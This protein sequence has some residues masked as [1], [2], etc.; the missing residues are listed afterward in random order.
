MLASLSVRTDGNDEVVYHQE[1]D[2]DEGDDDEDRVD[3]GRVLLV[4]THLPQVHLG[5]LE[6]RVEFQRLLEV[7]GCLLVLLQGLVDLAEGEVLEPRVLLLRGF[8]VEGPLGQEDGV[9]QVL[10]V[11]EDPGE[12]EEEV[13]VVGGDGEGLAEALDGE[14]RVAFD[15]P[16]VAYL[17][18]DRERLWI[19]QGGGGGWW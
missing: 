8:H 16:V 18:Q 5:H 15:S 7:E 12:V 9:F 1:H 3:V 14:L 13:R 11:E 19:L 2:E 6:P 10:E 4:Q 17:V